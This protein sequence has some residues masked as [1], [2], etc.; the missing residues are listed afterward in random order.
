MR[1]YQ[2]DLLKAALP[3]E[4]LRFG[5]FKLKSGRESD[6]FWNAAKMSSGQS[7][8]LQGCAYAGK[9]VEIGTDNFDVLFGPAEKGIPIVNQT[10]AALYVNHKIDK[11][12]VSDRKVPKEYGDPVDRIINGTLYKGDRVLIE[13]DVI[14]TRKTKKDE[15][16]M[17]NSLGMDLK[18]VGVLVGLN[19]KETDE[20]G[21]DPIAALQ[22]ELGIPVHY[23]LD[24]VTLFDSLHNTQFLGKVWV[25]DEKFNSFKNY[26]SRFGVK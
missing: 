21:Q 23:I 1:V 11:R 10:A 9:L 2:E 12:F 14:S 15:I 17:L 3:S 4:A 22:D 13:D 5:K 26:Y 7:A 24:S 25:D 18:I 6:Y 19:R 20:K 16:A 8:F